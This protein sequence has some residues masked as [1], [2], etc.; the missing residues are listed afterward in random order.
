MNEIYHSIFIDELQDYAGWDL[1]LFKTLF[2]SSIN[3]YCVGDN[4]QATFRT[5]NSIKNKQY[6]DDKIIGYF[7]LLEKKGNCN[8]EYSNITRRFNQEICDY[9][10][11]IHEDQS[12]PVIPD[13]C[14]NEIVDNTGVYII[15]EKFMDTYCECFK[16]IILRYN[17]TVNIPFEYNSQ[18]LNYGASKG[19]TFDRIA[20]IP[21]ATVIPFITS[22]NKIISNQT[23][24][25]FYVACTRAKHSIVFVMKNAIENELFSPVTIEVD[26]K[27]IPAFK[28][29]KLQE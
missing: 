12:N 17:I 26:G 9:I 6:R 22:L 2:E 18:V 8:V 24:S 15:D 23:R 27:S 3:I 13:S 10:N 19:C 4:K 1:E 5:N 11:L 25:K 20:I 7:K 21:P 29:K 16:P 14:L 28:F